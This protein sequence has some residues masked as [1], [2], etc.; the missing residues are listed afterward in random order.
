MKLIKASV[1]RPVGVIMIVLAIIALGFVSVRNLAV[2]LFPEIELP[3]AVVATNYEDAAPEDVENLI[4]RPVE[5]A[6]STVQGVDTVQSQSQSGA[7]LVMMMFKNGTDLDQAMLDVREKIDQMKG[8]LPEQAGDPSI[9]RFSP[10]ALPVMYIGLTGKDAATLT[11]LADNQIVPFLERQEGVASVTVEGAKIRE[12][13]LVVDPAKLQQYGVTTQ[14]IQ[15]ALGE[16]NQSASVGTV[17]KGNKDLQ[18]RVTGEFDS[19]DDIRETV[20]Q[21][22]S[23][24]ILHVDDVAEV[25]DTYKEASSASLVN[26]EESIVLSIMKQTDANTVAVANTVQKNLETIQAELGDEV[27]LDVIIDTSEFIQMSVDS[28]LSNII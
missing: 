8:M 2:D 20:I 28:V 10:E 16:S 26:G 23:G 18:L 25:K 13:Q 21:T 17:D 6:V 5:S 24:A 22:E 7:S 1:N 14:M 9:L 27:N 12:I 3:I 19:I 11:E 15:Q 4:S